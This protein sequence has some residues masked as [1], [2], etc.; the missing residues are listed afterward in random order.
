VLS[1][2][3]ALRFLLATDPEALTRVLGI[4]YRTISGYILKKAR[5]TR[6]SGATRAVTLIQRFGSAFN[7]NIHFHALVLDGA[8]L[9]GTE[10]PVFRRIEPPRQEELQALVER[11]AERIGRALERQGLLARD[12]ESSYLELGPEAGGP[13]DDLIGHSITYRVAVGPRAGQTVPC[14]L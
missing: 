3:F 11:L 1:L 10:P 5:L 9:V 14:V 7:L 4:V 12:A 8:Y 13:L 2:P 6:V